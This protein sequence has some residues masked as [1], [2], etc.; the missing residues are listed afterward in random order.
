MMRKLSTVA[1]CVLVLAACGGGA[2]Q[3]AQDQ[4]AAPPAATGATGATHDVNMVLEGT[5]YKYVPD[6]LTI[7]V[8]DAV[9]FHNVSGG[10]HNVQFWPDS[11][12]AG[13]ADALGAGMPDQMSPLAGPLLIDYTGP[14]ALYTIT[15]N[16]VPAGEYRFYCLPHLA[17]NMVGKITVAQ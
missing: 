11:I 10:P 8:G 13:A 17:N 14:G 2:E 12:P 1:G 15:F 4:A 6:Q 5:A 16:N 3:P 7:R 9:N